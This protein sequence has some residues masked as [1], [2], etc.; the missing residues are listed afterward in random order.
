MTLIK[1]NNQSTI[2]LYKYI[3]QSFVYGRCFGEYDKRCTSEI[4]TPDLQHVQ[5]LY[6]TACAYH[7]QQTII[8]ANEVELYNTQC[9][10][11]NLCAFYYCAI[12]Q[13][14]VPLSA[15]KE[16]KQNGDLDNLLRL[17]NYE[18]K[19]YAQKGNYFHNDLPLDTHMLQSIITKQ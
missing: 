5:N 4:W 17:V 19:I 10:N 6:N 15:Y 18:H 2:K 11:K 1:L 9:E 3:G 13:I 14:E 12:D 8:P 7:F 16:A